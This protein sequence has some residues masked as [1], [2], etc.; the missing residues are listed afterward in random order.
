MRVTTLHQRRYTLSSTYHTATVAGQHASRFHHHYVDEKRKKI[1]TIENTDSGCIRNLTKGTARLTPVFA[2]LTPCGRPNQNS[3]VFPVSR[4]T[5][6]AS[7]F[8][9]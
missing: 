6:S 8:E 4:G 9:I 2:T 5:K 3:K 7:L 1:A